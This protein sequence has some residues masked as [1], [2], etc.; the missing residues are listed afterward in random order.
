MP[1]SSY[2]GKDL[3]AHW[4]VDNNIKTILDVGVGAGT[5]SV[6]LKEK[7]IK[8]DKIDGIEAW[9]PYVEEFDLANKYDNLF[10]VDAREWEDWNYDLVIFGDVLEHMSKEDALVLWDKVSKQAKH[11]LISIPIIHYP[12]GHEHGN[13]YEEHVK[14]DWSTIEVIQSFKGIKQY[15]PYNVVGIFWATFDK[16]DEK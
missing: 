5:Y 1:G 15:F 11:A 9:A 12:Q 8:M 4:I 13:P 7:N 10:Q 16:E 2:E 6:I 3:S 14:D